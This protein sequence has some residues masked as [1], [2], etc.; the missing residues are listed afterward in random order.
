[1]AL[2]I[3]R[4]VKNSQGVSTGT[5]TGY[6]VELRSDSSVVKRCEILGLINGASFTRMARES[7]TS[8]P[9]Y[10]HSAALI[11][12]L[13]QCIPQVEAAAATSSTLDPPL[14]AAL[15]LPLPLPLCRAA[16]KHW[17]ETAR[18][19]RQ[20][21]RQIRRVLG[22]WWAQ[23]VSISF[24]CWQGAC[25]ARL[26][27]RK[28]GSR[29]ATNLRLHELK[30]AWTHFGEALRARRRHT[31][32]LQRVVSGWLRRDLLRCCVHWAQVAHVRRDCSLSIEQVA[33]RW[34]RADVLVSFERWAQRT[35]ARRHASHSL[36]CVVK[37]W[38]Q[39]RCARATLQWAQQA[40][41]RRRASHLLTR[42]VTRW[43]QRRCV[44][45]LLLWAARLCASRDELAH[46][47]LVAKHRRRWTLRRWVEVHRCR[48][49]A[50]RVLAMWHGW[51]LS[52]ALRQWTATH[53]ATR[54]AMHTK[55]NVLRRWRERERTEALRLWASVARARGASRGL[56]GRMV[57]RWIGMY[58]GR[59]LRCWHE[60]SLLL[61]TALFMG[62]RFAQRWRLRDAAWALRRLHAA[63]A[64]RGRSHEAEARAHALWRRLRLIHGYRRLCRQKALARVVH[65]WQRADKHC[66]FVEWRRRALAAVASVE[67]HVERIWWAA[68]ALVA[69]APNLAA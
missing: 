49:L 51:A 15:P 30:G 12:H 24:A 69:L 28:L 22:R 33:R 58:M 27:T 43:R 35:A 44:R 38:R 36:T 50:Q 61:K 68:A 34:L 11:E 53:E 63:A 47:A 66:A 40:A 41:A 29:V 14:R 55:V 57:A 8:P 59:A 7:P 39:R 10:F 19:Q 16:L 13:L 48:A 46:R 52:C 37:R 6:S 20:S 31:S 5:S 21:L 3:Y 9:L 56:Y 17:S 67:R 32:R 4:L 45:A 18:G 60:Q 25:E 1:M 65:R 64:A 26:R 54:L 42:V 2:L 62:R 23:R